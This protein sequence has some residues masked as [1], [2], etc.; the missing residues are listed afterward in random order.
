MSALSDDDDRSDNGLLVSSKSSRMFLMTIGDASDLSIS[1]RIG[2]TEPT[3]PVVRQLDSET[4]SLVVDRAGDEPKSESSGFNNSA[5]VVGGLLIKSFDL[6]KSKV[7]RGSSV[8]M[9]PAASVG[10][11]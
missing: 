2:D 4:R 10:G 7:G 3:L 5:T 11:R 6:A 8:V 1:H 9:S